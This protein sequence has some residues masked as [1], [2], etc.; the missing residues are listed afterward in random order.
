MKDAVNNISDLTRKG[1]QQDSA[2]KG[3]KSAYDAY[4]VEDTKRDE[5]CRGRFT[6]IDGNI[7]GLKKVGIIEFIKIFKNDL[8]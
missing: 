7:A 2:I 3:Q 1:E 4:V 5:G 6:G 8:N